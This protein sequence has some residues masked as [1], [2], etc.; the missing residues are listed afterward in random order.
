MNFWARRTQDNDTRVSGG[1]T[2]GIYGSIGICGVSRAKNVVGGYY[3]R[4]Q[5]TLRDSHRFCGR[6]CS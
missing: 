1:S 3:V 2:I 5:Y 4:R 6:K